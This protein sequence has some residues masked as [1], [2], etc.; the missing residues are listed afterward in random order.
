MK[1]DGR[2]DGLAWPGLAW[3][4]G[5]A[6]CQGYLDLGGSEWARVRDGRGMG[7]AGCWQVL[8]RQVF[9]SDCGSGWAW[10]LQAWAG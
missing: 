4:T 7:L 5:S 6:G 9:N 3:R 2:T 1:T 10:A 8:A